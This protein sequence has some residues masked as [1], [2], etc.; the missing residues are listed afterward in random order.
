M[1]PKDMAIRVTLFP[2]VAV[3]NSDLRLP[4]DVL[5]RDLRFGDKTHPMPPIP[6]SATRRWVVMRSSMSRIAED[7]P[8]NFG[9]RSKGT[10]KAGSLIDFT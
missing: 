5:T 9:S 8:T 4:I 10:R 6:Q 2:D 7:R 1:N 3:L